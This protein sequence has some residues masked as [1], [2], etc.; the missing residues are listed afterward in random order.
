MRCDV[1]NARWA[2]AKVVSVLAAGVFL[3]SCTT[4]TITPEL[5]QAPGRDYDK[6]VIGDIGAVDELWEPRLPFLRSALVAKL[7]EDKTFPQVFDRPP[8]PVPED[9]IVVSG[10]VSMIDKGSKA[11]RFII[12]FGAGRAKAAGMFSIKDAQGT[13][14]AR[15]ESRKAYSGG[16]GIGGFDMLDMDELMEALGEETARVIIRWTKGES[17]ETPTKN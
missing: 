9:A 10:R 16:A 17:L 6:V 4:T 15:F 14:L 3:A 7:R 2:W 11:L 8:E 13:T 5:V 1:S 12:G